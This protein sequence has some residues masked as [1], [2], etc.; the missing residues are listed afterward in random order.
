M[1]KPTSS[2]NPSIPIGPG[3]HV[4]RPSGRGFGQT[5]VWPAHAARVWVWK[6]GSRC[7]FH[8]ELRD[9]A[10]ENET[11]ETAGRRWNRLSSPKCP[12]GFGLRR[13]DEGSKRDEGTVDQIKGEIK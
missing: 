10:S 9:S 3:L 4:V 12:L 13:R 7:S 8:S 2:S 5:P 6:G 11:P 1:A